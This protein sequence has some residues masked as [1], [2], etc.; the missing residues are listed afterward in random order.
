M[1]VTQA[2]VVNIILEMEYVPN[3]LVHFCRQKCHQDLSSFTKMAITKSDIQKFSL[4]LYFSL[5]HRYSIV[6]KHWVGIKTNDTVR[7]SDIR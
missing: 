4:T 2:E 7:I 1:L 5:R 3:K 6:V